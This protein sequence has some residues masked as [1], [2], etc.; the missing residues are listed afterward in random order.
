[1]CEDNCKIVSI[2]GEKLMNI[3]YVEMLIESIEIFDKKFNPPFFI[4]FYLDENE[5]FGRPE[6]T[7]ITA[8]ASSIKPTKELMA[9]IMFN[10]KR[11]MG[12]MIFMFDYEILS[13]DDAIGNLEMTLE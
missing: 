7:Y 12:N 2:R 6:K 13:K 11:Q 5:E 9:D 8:L 10:H 3:E 1:M 4:L